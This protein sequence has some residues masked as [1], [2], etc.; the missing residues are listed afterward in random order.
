VGVP[1]QLKA[2]QKVTVPLGEHVGGGGT[3]Q[4]HALHAR[5]SSNVV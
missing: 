3:E 2:V 5:V 1:L 4:V